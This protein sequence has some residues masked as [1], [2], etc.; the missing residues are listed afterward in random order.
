[1]EVN[2]SSIGL[3]P[4]L[5]LADSNQQLIE[6]FGDDRC[7]KCQKGSYKC[8]LDPT[9]MSRKKCLSCFSA[10]CEIDPVRGR[11]TL[12]DGSLNDLNKA[13]DLIKALQ[14]EDRRCTTEGNKSMSMTDMVKELEGVI[15]ELEGMISCL[16][17]P[18]KTRLERAYWER[19]GNNRR[20]KFR[21]GHFNVS[22]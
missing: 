6:V 13:L 10:A 17:G 3:W 4:Q 5:Q 1:M 12:F 8:L 15:S 18:V 19:R 11:T 20:V 16:A 14:H 22:S 21:E 9:K 2:A 7:V